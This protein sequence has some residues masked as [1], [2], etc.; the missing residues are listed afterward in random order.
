M[1]L[2]GGRLQADSSPRLG[3]RFSLFAPLEN[4]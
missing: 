3:S 2:I 1:D 4:Q